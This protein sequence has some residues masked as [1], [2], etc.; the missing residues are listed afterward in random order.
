[1]QCRRTA[2]Q[3]KRAPALLCC[4]KRG[5]RAR[6][7]A[8]S[9]APLPRRWQNLAGASGRHH[10]PG[11]PRGLAWVHHRGK[12][13]VSASW[14]PRGAPRPHSGCRWACD[15]QER[16][17][18][19]CWSLGSGRRGPPGRGP[20]VRRTTTVVDG[21]PRVIQQGDDKVSCLAYVMHNR[22][23]WFLIASCH[24]PLTAVGASVANAS[25]I[26]CVES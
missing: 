2:V 18:A 13:Y 24:G 22:A 25:H 4:S 19:C 3:Q 17:V 20:A 16:R 9:D 1:M 26:P 11:S 14:P 12:P 23:A 6:A 15:M 10:R 8:P 5:P 21:A 7:W